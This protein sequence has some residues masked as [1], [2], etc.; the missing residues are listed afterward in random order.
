M[1][2]ALVTLPRFIQGSRRG[3]GLEDE[4]RAGVSLPTDRAAADLDLGPHGA[5]AAPPQ[6]LGQFSGGL[7]GWKHPGGEAFY[8]IRN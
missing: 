2:H 8:R 4:S 6:H 1:P 7:Y 5:G 3:D